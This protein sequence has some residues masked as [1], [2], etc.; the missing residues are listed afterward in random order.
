MLA[1]GMIAAALA[2]AALFLTKAKPERRNK[3]SQ[4]LTGGKDV[5]SSNL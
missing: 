2:A 5:V 1:T 4:L 3:F